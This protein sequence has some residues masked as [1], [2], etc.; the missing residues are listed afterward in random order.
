MAPAKALLHALTQAELLPTEGDNR[1]ALIPDLLKNINGS[2]LQKLEHSG[3]KISW[4]EVSG[5][6]MF[7]VPAGWFVCTSSMGDG[8]TTAIAQRMLLKKAKGNTS[9]QD[10]INAILPL[11]GPIKQASIGMLADLLTIADQS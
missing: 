1:L 11:L 10:N 2:Q 3:L 4:L 6:E 5:G 7:F 8:P 9:S